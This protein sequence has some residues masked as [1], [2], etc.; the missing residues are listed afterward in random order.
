[1]GA[2]AFS[3]QP[4]HS[5]VVAGWAL[6]QILDDTTLQHSEDFE[7]ATQFDQAKDTDGLMVYLLPRDL[8]ARVTSAIRKTATGILSGTVPSGVA[9]QHHGDER[10]VAQYREALRELLEALPLTGTPPG[11]GR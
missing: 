10:T 9:K 11:T 5:W 7:M 8:A 6:R 2:I 3:E 4:E 1:M